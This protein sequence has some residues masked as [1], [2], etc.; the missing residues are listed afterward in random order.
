MLKNLK[1]NSAI[2][3]IVTAT[4]KLKNNN[5]NENLGSRSAV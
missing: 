5:K 3:I 1:F 2:K 4:N